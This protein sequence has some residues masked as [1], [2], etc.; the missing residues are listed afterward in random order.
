M[1]SVGSYVTPRL[2]GG[3]DGLMFGNVIADQF[4]ASFNWSWGATLSI[5]LTVATLALV[6]LVARKVP[7][8]RVFLNS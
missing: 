1:L 4:G 6:A 8:A 5:A 3:P 2:V 7:L